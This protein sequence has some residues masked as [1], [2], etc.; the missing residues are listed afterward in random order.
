[1]KRV[2]PEGRG[3][4]WKGFPPIERSALALIAPQKLLQP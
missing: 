4:T 1:M 3:D 2:S